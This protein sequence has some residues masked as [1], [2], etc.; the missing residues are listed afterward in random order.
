MSNLQGTY[1]ASVSLLNQPTGL[2][3]AGLLNEI[4]LP[5]APYTISY[6]YGTG[7]GQIDA[8]FSVGKFNSYGTTYSLTGTSSLNLT[9]LINAVGNSVSFARIKGGYF[10]NNTA[11][12]TLTLGGG[13]NAFNTAFSTMIL[14]G[15]ESF[16]FGVGAADSTGHVVTPS[17]ACNLQLVASATLSAT[18]VLWGTSV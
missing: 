14:R 6:T 4:L 15:G 13:S 3:T 7:A 16:S 10:L 12:T 17:T 1:S 9:S 2:N 18:I 8:V 5:G 11:G